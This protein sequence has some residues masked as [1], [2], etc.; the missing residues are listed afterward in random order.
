MNDEHEKPE[1]QLISLCACV[2][3]MKKHRKQTEQS[4]RYCWPFVSY[5]ADSYSVFVFLVIRQ[6]S[7]YQDVGS[8]VIP[9]HDLLRQNNIADVVCR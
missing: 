9:T 3:S 5:K 7:Q 1:G 4:I 2:P 6:L 8:S